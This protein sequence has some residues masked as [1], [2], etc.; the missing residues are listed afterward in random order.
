MTQP[1][2]VIFTGIPGSGKTYFAAH[3]E[4]KLKAVR[5][6]SDAMRMAIFGSLDAIEKVYHSDDRQHVNSYVFGAMD[7]VTKQVIEAGVSVIYEGIQMT[8]ADRRHMEIIAEQTS[9]VLVLV[10]MCI[11]KST[12]IERVQGRAISHESRQFDARKAEE[13]IT[14]FTEKFEP[15]E[16]T[17]YVVAIDGTWPFD[18]QYQVFDTFV[19]TLM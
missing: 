8:R 19:S 10:D 13:V 1:L 3:L 6:N 15:F 9:T 12:A 17:D 16:R 2:L 11:D 5:L 4:E 7:Y 14:H 18:K